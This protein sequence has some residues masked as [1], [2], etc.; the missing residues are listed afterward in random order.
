MP[1]GPL[2]NYEPKKLFNWVIVMI[3]LTVL[4]QYPGLILAIRW[5]LEIIPLLISGGLYLL[6]AGYIA[7][8]FNKF[9]RS[10]TL[11]SILFLIYGLFLNIY[12]FL[13]LI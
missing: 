4:P 1:P 9:C 3:A 6:M 5:K 8:M 7:F 11:G 10:D 2:E 12:V 13:I